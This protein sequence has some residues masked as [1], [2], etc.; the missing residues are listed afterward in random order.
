MILALVCIAGALLPEQSAS[1]YQPPAA[2]AVCLGQIADKLQHA[3]PVQIHF[4][5]G[6]G[7]IFI[8]PGLQ[9]YYDSVL[10][11]DSDGSRFAREDA[12]GRRQDPTGD[13]N[14][15]LR[16]PNPKY[17]SV[18][19]DAIAY[20]VLPSGFYQRFGI[21]LGDVAAVIYKNNVEFAIFADVGPRRKL[22]EGSIALHRALGHEP[23]RNGRY[24][25][26]AIK[27][28]VIT[29]V[30]PG[31]GNDTPQTPDRIRDIGRALFVK[32]G[33]K[34]CGRA[35]PGLAGKAPG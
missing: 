33:G 19:A 8:L 17:D 2:S 16:Y 25:D 9:L 35:T 27:G 20:F 15:S 22:G 24:H 3:T 23:I 12:G 4:D 31:S 32:L 1:A 6:G 7:A 34:P 29:I 11:L 30:F 13:P 28:N 5:K 21:H 10:D 26:E 14:T 18:D